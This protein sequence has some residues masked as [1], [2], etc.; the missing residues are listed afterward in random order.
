MANINLQM[1]WRN[2]WRNKLRSSVVIAAITVGLFG[3]LAASGI[4]KGMVMDMIDN[5]LENTVSHIQIHDEHFIDN[6]EVVFL[7]KNSNI[8][9]QKIN[10]EPEVE[11]VCERTKAF[12][13][14]ST[15]SKALGVMINGI[16]PDKEKKV[17]KIYTKLTDSLSSYFT[18]EKK[19]RILIS[20][21]LA[22]K[23]NAKVKSKIILTFQDYDGNLTGASFK[24]EGIFKT[25]NAMFDEQNVFVRKKDLDRLLNMPAN[26]SHEIA[27]LLKDYHKT[28]EVV[29]KLKKITSYHIEAWNKIDPYL[30]LTTSLTGFML[31]IFMTVILLALGFAIVNT[32]LMVI[33]ER[34]KELGMIM[35]IGM[36]K[37]K[38]FIMIMQETTLLTL[39]GGILGILVSIIFITYFGKAGIDISGVAQ[40]IEAL[41]YS[42][43]M[44]PQLSLTDYLQVIVMVLLT[45]IISS[46]FPTIRAIKMKPAEAVRM[47]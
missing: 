27:V 38:V 17:T 3:G 40:G 23:L 35:A 33:L 22:D 11:A 46:I 12:G 32:M 8:L 34:T 24:V 1:A 13:M 26:T 42:S 28:P 14:A 29:D 19:N 39:T 7:M 4:M 6:S 10:S 30:E 44:Y 41:G 37:R 9:V 36:N 47:D 25:Q 20:Q 15:A 31:L 5:A 43:V 18:T 2:I 21:K 16:E 45:G